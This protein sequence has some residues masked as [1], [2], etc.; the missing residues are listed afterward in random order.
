MALPEVVLIETL[1]RNGTRPGTRMPDRRKDPRRHDGTW[2]DRCV[3]LAAHRIDGA[4][5]ARVEEAKKAKKS[6]KKR[7][8]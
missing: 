6:A 4:L 7:S 8:P 1:R 2:S 3:R 5:K